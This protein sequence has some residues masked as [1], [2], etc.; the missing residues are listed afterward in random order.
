M[1]IALGNMGVRKGVENEERKFLSRGNS[2][3]GRASRKPCG[4]KLP[5]RG[6]ETSKIFVS[7]ARGSVQ[8]CARRRRVPG[9]PLCRRRPE[10][11]SQDQGS[12][13]SGSQS[14]SQIPCHIHSFLGISR[15]A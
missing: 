15:A 13:G 2:S 11:E 8:H 10:R 9:S 6:R 7:A 4:S 3:I 5:A 12:Q 1:R 14:I